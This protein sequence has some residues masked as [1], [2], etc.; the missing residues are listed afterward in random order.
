MLYWLKTDV[1]LKTDTLL[2]THKDNN[3]TDSH[4]WHC[5]LGLASFHAIKHLDILKNEN[6]DVNLNNFNIYIQAK[7]P[8]LSF[9]HSDTKST[10]CFQLLHIDL[11]GPYKKPAH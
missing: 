11:W 9:P 10:A 7:Q 5:R 3:L 6:V 1:N 8:R 4:T 2:A